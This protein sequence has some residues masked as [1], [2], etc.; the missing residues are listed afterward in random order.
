MSEPLPETPAGDLNVP[1][2]Q[3]QP[4]TETPP[5]ETPAPPPTA[6]TV[7]EG[8]KTERELE[9]EEE[10]A[11]ERERYMQLEGEKK[12]VEIDHAHL[13]DEN[14]RLKTLVRSTPQPTKQKPVRAKSW[15]LFDEE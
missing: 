10:L 13:D 8:T 5:K 9:L 7:L 12:R 6:K 11:G 1:E 3:D 4:P 2:T 14:R 15:T